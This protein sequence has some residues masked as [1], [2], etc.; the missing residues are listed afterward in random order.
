MAESQT[1]LP[2]LIRRLLQSEAW[3]HDADHP[4]L[5]E[6]HISWVI[7]NR[8]SPHKAIA[9]GAA[10]F[11]GMQL[12]SPATVSGNFRATAMFVPHRTRPS[13]FRAA[14]LAALLLIVA[15]CAGEPQ[16]VPAPGAERVSPGGSIAVTSASDVTVTVDPDAWRGSVQ[17]G[18]AVT[19]MHVKIENQSDNKL[20]IRYSDFAMIAGNGDRY[21]ALPPYDIR[22]TVAGP[23]PARGYSP[24]DRLGFTYDGFYVA[25]FY[26]FIYPGLAVYD[27]HPFLFDPLYYEHYYPYWRQ[28]RVE[29]PT[30]EMLRFALPEG[31]LEE[32]GVL[33]GF[34]YF[35][36][37]DAEVSPVTFQADVVDIVSGKMIATLEIPFVVQQDE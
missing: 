25:P 27:G 9:S 23:A 15:G 36:P 31:M 11:S 37:V 33:A 14:G 2:E 32:G 29:L 16:L 4:E 26:R 19:P 34:L 35:E 6:T 18:N 17:I 30:A 24:V 12:A 10:R 3:P 28:A 1:A 7:L 13:L 20:R 22:G 21:A 8:R 5:I